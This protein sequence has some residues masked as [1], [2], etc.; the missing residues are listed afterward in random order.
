M[1]VNRGA[2]A[3]PLAYL[4]G[5]ITQGGADAFVQ[6]SITTGLSGETRKAYRV[7][8]LLIE[9]PFG[10]LPEVDSNLEVAFT[11]KSV[12]SMASIADKH[13]IWRFKRQLIITT[14]GQ[15]LWD[16]LVERVFADDE[17]LIVEDPLYMCLDSNGT[18][19]SNA[20]TFALG[21]EEVAIADD[22]RLELLVNSL[23]S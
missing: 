9:L 16:V 19:A 7:R 15:V 20:A 3:N 6:A 10:T 12:S 17:F 2:R 11:R 8:H 4:R 13:T 1:S 18:S 22:A 14:S 5:T 23:G 21:Y